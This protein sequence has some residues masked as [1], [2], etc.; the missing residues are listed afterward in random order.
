MTVKLPT[1][2][3][4][5]DAAAALAPYAPETPLVEH[6]DLNE[7]VGARVF[8]KLETFQRTGSFKF[9]GAFNRIRQ[10]APEDRAKGVVAFSSGNHAQGVAAAAALFSMPALIVMPK[11]VPAPK[12]EG[13]ARFGRRGRLLRPPHGR[14]RGH[15]AGAMPRA[16]CDIWSAR[17]TIFMSWRGKGP[18][19]WKWRAKLRR[20]A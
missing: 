10:I 8:L 7:R 9:R 17:S 20:A 14:P 3:D 11:D 15:R 16:G 18:S 13:T 6:V 2:A 19:V 12:L 1:F 4:I 5:E